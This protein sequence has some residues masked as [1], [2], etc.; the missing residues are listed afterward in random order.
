MMMM[1]KQKI[2]RL[3]EFHFFSLQH[4]L[5]FPYSI[6][7]VYRYW[8]WWWWWLLCSDDDGWLTDLFHFV[9]FLLLSLSLFSL[10]T[11]TSFTLIIIII[12]NDSIL[13]KKYQDQI[14]LIE[15]DFSREKEIM[16]IQSCHLRQDIDR[17]MNAVQEQLSKFRSNIKILEEVYTYFWH[18]HQKNSKSL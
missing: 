2:N 13:E 18:K 12:I 14:R 1:M 9:R 3:I 16:I 4:F 7:G 5:H 17:Q 11:H 10:H 15:M 6:L 8:T